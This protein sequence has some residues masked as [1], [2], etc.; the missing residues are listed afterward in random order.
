MESQME[1]WAKQKK[2][3]ELELSEDK[4]QK[5]REI[6]KEQEKWSSYISTIESMDHNMKAREDEVEKEKDEILKM[7]DE[8]EV[9]HKVYSSEQPGN[10]RKSWITCYL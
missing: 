9:A 4:R 7:R 10:Y 6:V 2:R 1:E 8:L 3:E 5:R